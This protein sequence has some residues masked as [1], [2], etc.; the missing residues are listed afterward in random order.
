MNVGRVGRGLDWLFEARSACA[1][2]LAVATV[3]RYAILLEHK[4]QEQRFA[5]TFRV[6]ASHRIHADVS[7]RYNPP[8]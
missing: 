2:C 1:R 4:I 7:C 8:T 6:L 3:C 5:F